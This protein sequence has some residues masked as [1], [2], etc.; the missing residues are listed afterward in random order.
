[1]NAPYYP[2]GAF[3][4]TV[5][6]LGSATALASLVSADA[7]FAE[8]TGLKGEFGVEQV[9]EGGENRFAHRLPKAAMY[10][11]LVLKRGVVT[12][13]S[14]LAEWTYNTVGS[15]MSLPVL[16]QNLAV[17]LLDGEGAPSIVWVCVNAYPIRWEIGAFNA[18]ENKVLTE[19]MEFSY[20]YVERI[21]LG[22]GLS[23]ATQLARL[24]KAAS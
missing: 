7:A 19:T 17:S 4:F 14:V 22:S 13:D 21:N 3:H 5:S 11:N 23:A 6:V 8:V 10:P 12:G 15:T 24:A 1:M 9:V 16:T 20:N 18:T 2:P